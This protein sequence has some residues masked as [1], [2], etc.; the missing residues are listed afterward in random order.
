MWEVYNVTGDMGNVRDV[1]FFPFECLF[2]MF[3]FLNFLWY[4]VW[5][6]YITN[7]HT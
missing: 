7:R 5:L 1:T 3:V 4:E 2:L 6:S